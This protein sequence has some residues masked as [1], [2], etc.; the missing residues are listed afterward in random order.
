[1]AVNVVW[2]NN[3]YTVIRYDFEHPWKLEDYYLAADEVAAQI[4]LVKH[5]VNVLMDLTQSRTLPTQILPAAAR[6]YKIMPH[7][8]GVAVV[9]G[10]AYVAGMVKL[11]NTAYPALGS[12][13][14]AVKTMD[15]ARDKLAQAIVG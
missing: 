14:I 10:N 11:F 7:N 5:R 3:N 1:M 8:F 6:A 12:R 2:D 4:A 15:E 9:A 13:M